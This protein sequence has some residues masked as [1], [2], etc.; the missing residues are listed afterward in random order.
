MAARVARIA[1]PLGIAS[2]GAEGLYQAGKFT[3]KRIGEL[4]AMTPEQ[5]QNLRAQQEALAFEGARDGGLIG[6]KSGP[7]PES[8]PQP[9]GLPGI[10]KRGKKL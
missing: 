9:Q 3:K 6:D 7:A 4:K 8:G 1:S 10:Y 2:L 5:R